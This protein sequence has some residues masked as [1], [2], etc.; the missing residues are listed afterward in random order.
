M[1]HYICLQSIFQTTVILI[2]LFG[3]DTFI[4]IDKTF[5]SNVKDYSTNPSLRTTSMVFTSFILLQVTNLI[6]ARSLKAELNVVFK[7]I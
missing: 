5:H 6:C 3:A 2:L 7:I 4:P 1:W